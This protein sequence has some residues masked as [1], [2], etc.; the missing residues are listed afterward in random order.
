MQVA[1]LAE[2]ELGISTIHLSFDSLAAVGDA[3]E[4][5]LSLETR[6][7]SVLCSAFPGGFTC[8]ASLMS[9]WCGWYKQR[10][11][12][13]SLTIMVTDMQFDEY[14]HWSSNAKRWQSLQNLV[15][16]KLVLY[17]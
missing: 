5:H 13:F 1:P 9:S 6:E 12:S 10:A 7:A 2:V 17:Y 16:L 8:Q 4:T 14:I 11:L 3:A 15:L